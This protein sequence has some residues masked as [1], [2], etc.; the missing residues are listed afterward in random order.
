M[1]CLCSF[2]LAL[3]LGIGA[4]TA[5]ENIDSLS[6]ALG[7]QYTLATMAGSNALIQKQQDL[8]DYIHGLE[9][10]SK[11]LTMTNDSSYMKS[12]YLGA[13]E[14]VYLKDG[15]FI[16]REKNLTPFSCIITGLRK[17][18]NG[19]IS[20]PSDTVA[21]MDLI[22]KYGNKD[23]NKTDLDE[24]TK[25]RLYS[26]YGVM[27]AFKPGLQKYINELNPGTSCVENILAFASGMADMLEA[28]TEIPKSAYDL[29]RVISFS[30][31]FRNE[32]I[33][34]MD[35]PSFVAGAKALFGLGAQIIPRDETEVIIRCWSTQKSGTVG[36]IDQ[37]EVFERLMEYHENL[38]VKFDTPYTVNWTVT[39]GR[40]A[41]EQT[42]VSKIFSKVILELNIDDDTTNGMLMV[43][44]RD[45]DGYIYQSALSAIKNYPL[46][47]GYKW[48]Y[49]RIDGVHTTIGIMQTS[50]LFK[51]D[52]HEAIVEFETISNMVIVKWTFDVADALNWERFTGSNIGKHVAVEIN[53][54]FMFAPMINQQI[55][56]NNGTIN[57]LPLE[58]INSLFKGSE[59]IG[60]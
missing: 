38:S 5:R 25:C 16:K 11:Y 59:K 23:L 10:T 14:A 44:P 40:V 50:P 4:I 6:Y 12:Y 20:L 46:P 47:D 19:E 17:V 18:V 27:K 3:I 13:M 43:Q 29:G 15:N 49:G 39:A 55:T 31:Y 21:A 52:I 34:F 57:N 28:S 51:A 35:M 8:E 1:K 2:L 45:E 41:D 22:N 33:E 7:Y 26:A 60:D 36:E 54:S 56:V 30:T 58:V 42:E 9:D 53:G 48:F 24:E 32:G 37:D